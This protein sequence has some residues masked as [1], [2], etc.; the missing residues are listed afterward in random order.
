MSWLE[1]TTYKH[2]CV[3]TF[4]KQSPRLK[5]LYDEHLFEDLKAHAS[6]GA[7]AGRSKDPRKRSRVVTQILEA[8]TYKDSRLSHGL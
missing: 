2:P 7:L 1:A 8:T 5:P 3:V 6:T 4:E